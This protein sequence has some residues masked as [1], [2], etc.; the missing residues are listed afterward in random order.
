MCSK[1]GRNADAGLFEDLVAATYIFDEEC[2]DRDR[3]V[4]EDSVTVS[5]REDC[6]ETGQRP[7]TK[8]TLGCTYD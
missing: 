1:R 7:P 8:T 6:P 5:V 2:R 3:G 4:R